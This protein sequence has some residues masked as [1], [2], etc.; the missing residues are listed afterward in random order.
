MGHRGIE[1]RYCSE[2]CKTDAKNKRTAYQRDKVRALFLNE[3]LSISEIATRM[4]MS[5]STGESSIRKNLSQWVKLKHLISDEL[6]ECDF[7]MAPLFNRCL[8]EQLDMDRMLS[9][10][11]RRRL[12]QE[13]RVAYERQEES[14]VIFLRALAKAKLRFQREDD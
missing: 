14:D 8:E 13:V 7:G 5:G 11:L 9:S 3:G 6:S 4:D 1:R 10:S 2:S 12:V